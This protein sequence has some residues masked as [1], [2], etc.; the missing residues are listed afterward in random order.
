VKKIRV[1]IVEDHEAVRRAISTLLA[2]SG[3]IEL[4]GE[5]ASAREGIDMSSQL[6][7]DVILLDIS[8]PDFSGL[9]AAPMIQKAVPE[10]KI[11]VVSQHDPVHMLSQAREA[12]ARGYV[13]KSKLAR[14]LLPAI[15]SILEVEA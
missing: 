5:A 14:D 4:C 10:G 13:T 6:R 11:L 2:R 1:L 9:E 3:E 15:R 7:P 12:G 8:L